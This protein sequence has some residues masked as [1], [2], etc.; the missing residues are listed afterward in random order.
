MNEPKRMIHC[1]E[2]S[3]DRESVCLLEDG[4]EG[5]HQFTP[6]G[7]VQIAFLPVSGCE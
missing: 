4:H 1:W 7:D 2:P 5:P 6:G 3:E